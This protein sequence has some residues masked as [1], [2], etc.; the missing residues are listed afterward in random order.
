VWEL[1]S[2]RTRVWMQPHDVSLMFRFSE[3]VIAN[4]IPD[5]FAARN[6]AMSVHRHGRSVIVLGGTRIG[7]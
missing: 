3:G 7:C 5:A 6:F 4:S 1:C 2:C